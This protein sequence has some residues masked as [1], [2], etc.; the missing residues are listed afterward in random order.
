MANNSFLRIKFKVFHRL[1]L[2]CPISFLLSCSKPQT[3]QTARSGQMTLAVDKQLADIAESQVKMF[4]SYY[5]DAHVSVI[6]VVSKKSL[7][8]LLDH[9]VSS[10]L[11]GGA[12]EAAE[13][14]LFAKE[15][16]PLR[17]EPVARDAL[18]C[19]VNE[20][21]PLKSISLEELKNTFTGRNERGMQPLVTADDFRLQSLFAGIMGNKREDLRAWGCSS[22]SALVKRI[23]ADNSAVGLLFQSSPEMRRLSKNAKSNIRILPL[24]KE[25]RSALGLLPTQ[26]NIYDGSY[27][28]VTTVYYVY[29]S[30]D[31]LAAGFGAWIRSAGQKAFERSSL[32]PFQLVERTIILN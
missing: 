12:P 32:A 31:P 14:S 20:R 22:D 4:R 28:L 17:R 30:S 3:E 15:N 13:E 9:K 2:L 6:P 10:A 19:I 7:K 27:P 18:V 24:S 1:L 23:S 8:L 25:S 5:P 29:Y 16:S 11:I 21:N 26:Q